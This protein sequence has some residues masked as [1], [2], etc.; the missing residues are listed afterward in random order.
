MGIDFRIQALG[1][2]D[3]TNALV[4]QAIARGEAEGLVV[5]ALRQTAGYG[6]L[7]HSWE[8]P[9][10]GLYCSV[11]LR[12]QVSDEVL[13]TLPLVV[14]MTVRDACE[15]MGAA[16]GPAGS[17]AA[18]ALKWPNDVFMEDQ[19]RTLFEDLHYKKLALDKPY[20]KV[21]GISCERYL[22]GVCIGIGVDAQ[23]LPGAPAPEAMLEELLRLFAPRYDRWLATGFAPFVSEFSQHHLL[24]GMEV[25]VED[26]FGRV[27]ARGVVQ[28]V[29]T[30][31]QLV[32]AAATGETR[33][34]SSGEAHIAMAE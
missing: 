21:A 11:L 32:I 18:F 19:G 27:Q 14:G 24:E 5:Q 3:S 33:A 29:N 16:T 1:E 31:G 23:V 13:A 28:S 9:E 10:G 17:T 12:P 30:Q 6:R 20:V 4:K 22:D 26:A 34:V 15:A 7:G 25:T 2:V 8:S